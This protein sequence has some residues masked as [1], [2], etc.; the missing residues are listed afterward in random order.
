MAAD[1]FS[2]D[3]ERKAGL[4]PVDDNAADKYGLVLS[5]AQT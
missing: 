5:S 2:V 3:V 1:Y 4:T